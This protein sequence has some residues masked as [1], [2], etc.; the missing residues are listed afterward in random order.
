MRHDN[1]EFK[2]RYIKLPNVT[3]AERTALSVSTPGYVLLNSDTGLVETFDGTAWAASNSFKTLSVDKSGA[4]TIL[5]AK[6]SGVSKLT[7]S[8]TLISSSVPISLPNATTFAGGL[9]LGGAASSTS[10]YSPAQGAWYLDAGANS[11]RLLIGAGTSQTSMIQFYVNALATNAGF[12][13]RN[14]SG[15]ND[16][17]VQG[18]IGNLAL[19][20]G[21]ADQLTLSST[22]VTS[23]VPVSAP[24]LT[25]GMGSRYTS[26]SSGTAGIYN[27]VNIAYAR[28]GYVS[29]V[30]VYRIWKTD[31]W[32]EGAYVDVRFSMNTIDPT[33]NWHIEIIGGSAEMYGDIYY[34]NTFDAANRYLAIGCFTA[35]P[36]IYIQCISRAN[37]SAGVSTA[38]PVNTIL[39]GPILCPW[40]LSVSRDSITASVPILYS[41]VGKLGSPGGAPTIYMMN[42][43]S[44]SDY[45]FFCAPDGS[46]GIGGTSVE[47]NVSSSTMF[48]V[49]R[50]G[51]QIL[52]VGDTAITASVPIV[53]ASKFLSLGT[54]RQD[55]TRSAYDSVLSLG[56]KGSIA[57]DPTY[58]Q[59]LNHNIYTDAVGP[60]AVTTGGA[61]YAAISDTAF[62]VLFAPSVS[63][64]TALAPV[65]VLGASPTAITASVP[66][67]R[68]FGQT[69]STAYTATTE[70]T[71][72]CVGGTTCLITMPVAPQ[73]YRTMTIINNN[74]GAVTAYQT[75]QPS[76]TVKMIY[77]SNAWVIVYRCSNA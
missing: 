6:A 71:I 11:A 53:A 44:A 70:D 33:E 66:F 17:R 2:G 25:Y 46:K 42:H 60:K 77:I 39:T 41:T 24:N 21:G 49:K 76:T 62:S 69:S 28:V 27:C 15:T 56:A 73:Q 26:K 34:A 57:S 35:N 14:V 43:Q 59:S 64:G 74:S 37:N 38:Y 30:A 65:T 5:A 61:G 13:G 16:F 36:N 40:A 58:G 47:I 19:G 68:T 63:A 67:V 31:T 45:G 52:A 20:G 12:I 10:I 4:G 72:R 3:T 32:S 50:S 23:S 18:L 1:T 48:V 51:S 75:V 7:V 54:T 8:D 29:E 55:N 9:A 22:A